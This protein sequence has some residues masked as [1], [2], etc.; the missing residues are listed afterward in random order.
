MRVGYVEYTGRCK[1]CG[2]V[3]TKSVR[4]RDLKRGVGIS[5]CSRSCA[6]RRVHSA[7]TRSKIGAASRITGRERVTENIAAYYT[8]PKHC[9]VCDR[10]L[11]YVKRQY[12]TCCREHARKLC[13]RLLHERA[14]SGAYSKLGGNRDRG[15]RSKSGYYNG[16]FMA[17]TFE[18]AYYIYMTSTGHAVDRCKEKFSYTLE[19]GTSRSY[20]PDFVLD[21]TTIV[22]VKGYMSPIVLRKAD[23]V[24]SSGRKFQ[25]VTY[26]D[27]VPAMCY[28]DTTFG[29]HHSRGANDYWKLYDKE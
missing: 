10:V 8:H 18:L 14:K 1:N 3:F 27:L 9:L 21:G 19:D 28:L 20:Y 22:E 29:C 15:G 24:I 23:A 16:V 6:N 5:F 25:L 12:S 2:A 4:K 13:G 17:S 11:P 26:E 7:E